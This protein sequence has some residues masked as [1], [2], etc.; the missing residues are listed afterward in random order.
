[1]ILPQ[2]SLQQILIKF[3]TFYRQLLAATMTIAPGQ[4]ACDCVSEKH[5][6]LHPRLRSAGV[7]GKSSVVAMVRDLVRNLMVTNRKDMFVF[8]VSVYHLVTWLDCLL[9]LFSH[10]QLPDKSVF[11]CRM[12]EDSP[13]KGDSRRSSILFQSTMGTTENISSSVDALSGT[14]GIFWSLKFHLSCSKI[15]FHFYLCQS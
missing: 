3:Q 10:S 5:I 6:P 13:S 9:I 2:F 15:F 11:Y 14:P 7:K 8:L 1:M 12:E 4:F